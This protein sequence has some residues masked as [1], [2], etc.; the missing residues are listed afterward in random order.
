[1]LRYRPG[2]VLLSR[3][4]TKLRPLLSVRRRSPLQNQEHRTSVKNLILVELIFKKSCQAM[5]PYQVLPSP[6]ISRRS[7]RAKQ[8]VRQLHA[9]VSAL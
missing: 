7:L 6:R 2:N 5:Q 8:A 3:F 1:M 9:L 4:L